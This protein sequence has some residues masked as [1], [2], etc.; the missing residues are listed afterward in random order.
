MFY[1]SLNYEDI[2]ENFQLSQNKIV[3]TYSRTGDKR[4]RIILQKPKDFRQLKLTLNEDGEEVCFISRFGG[5]LQSQ[6]IKYSA[7]MMVGVF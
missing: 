6:L 3:K 7:K 1:Q 5:Q 2:F 4:G